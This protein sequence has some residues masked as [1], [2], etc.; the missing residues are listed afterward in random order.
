[1]NRHTIIRL[2]GLLVLI[3]GWN[4]AD[5]RQEASL[6]S[7]ATRSLTKDDYLVYSA[8]IRTLPKSVTGVPVL[9]Y[10]KVTPCPICIEKRSGIE[11]SYLKKFPSIP[12][13]RLWPFLIFFDL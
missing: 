12:L 11:E 8:L 6:Q 2:V 5:T 13:A 7:V 9:I 10:N 1:M 4:L 3:I